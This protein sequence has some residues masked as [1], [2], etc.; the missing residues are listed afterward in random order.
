MLFSWWWGKAKGL[1]A[2]TS[3]QQCPTHPLMPFSAGT[4]AG[5][6]QWV[7]S[8]HSAAGGQ[9]QRR[10]SG[11][12]IAPCSAGPALLQ[13]PHRCKIP[14]SHPSKGPAPLPFPGKDSSG[15][16]APAPP[17]L[18][19]P[20]SPPPPRKGGPNTFPNISG[21]P[22]SSSIWGLG[23]AGVYHDMERLGGCSLPPS[24]GSGPREPPS[25]TCLPSSLSLLTLPLLA[26]LVC[27]SKR[28]VSI[29]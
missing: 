15:G 5:M 19:A 7:P 8:A 25:N 23:D 10:H 27:C 12:G 6:L 14:P 13:L 24:A 21:I 17:A 2:P 16:A 18:P 4:R 22:P 26:V 3:S 9:P 1:F 11:Q 28:V 29:S 20:C